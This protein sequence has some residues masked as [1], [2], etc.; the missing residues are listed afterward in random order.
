MQTWDK[1]GI[2]SNVKRE[3]VIKDYWKTVVS[4]L[5]KTDSEKMKLIWIV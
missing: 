5:I 1:A 3:L 2:V 4:T